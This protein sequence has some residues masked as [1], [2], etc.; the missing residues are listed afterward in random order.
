MLASARMELF[1]KVEKVVSNILSSRDAVRQMVSN[2]FY[3]HRVFGED[4]HF[5]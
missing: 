3:F 1:E 5:D 4:S 2:I